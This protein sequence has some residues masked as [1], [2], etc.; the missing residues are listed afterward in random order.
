MIYTVGDRESYLT[1]FARHGTVWK[2]GRES[3]HAPP[4]YPGGYAF[5]TAADARRRLREEPSYRGFEVFGVAAAWNR[6]TTPSA[7]GWWH[8]LRRDARAYVLAATSGTLLAYPHDPERWRELGTATP[9]AVVTYPA[10]L[11]A[12][13]PPYLET[14]Q[15]FAV[16]RSD[17]LVGP[18]KDPREEKW[19]PPSPTWVWAEYPSPYPNLQVPSTTPPRPDYWAGP[20]LASELARFWSLKLVIVVDAMKWGSR[21]LMSPTPEHVLD[22]PVALRVLAPS[23]LDR[24]APLL[25]VEGPPTCPACES[26]DTEGAIDGGS[27]CL[28]CGNAL[29]PLPR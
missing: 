14:L 21:G 19:A 12:S 29:G 25:S 16:A 15:V 23:P 6:D 2:L 5:R 22:S 24:G 13:R 28:A 26:E 18:A 17:A 1:A 11:F 9:G 8:H 20:T 3:V 10:R 7:E 27:R 4:G